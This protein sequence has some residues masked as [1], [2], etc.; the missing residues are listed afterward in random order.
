M[1]EQ[2]LRERG[3]ANA[4]ARVERALEERFVELS[5]EGVRASVRAYATLTLAR[6]LYLSTKFSER[7]RL[8]EQLLELCEERV[9]RQSL[10]LKKL[11]RVAAGTSR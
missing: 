4:L 3:D 9:R 7:Q 1:T 6:H 2:A 10:L 11:S 8:T 5:G